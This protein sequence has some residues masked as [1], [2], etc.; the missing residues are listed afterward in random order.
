MATE[1]PVCLGAW[2]FGYVE[3]QI[4]GEPLVFVVSGFRDCRVRGRLLERKVV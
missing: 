2:N 4:P 3:T 1:F